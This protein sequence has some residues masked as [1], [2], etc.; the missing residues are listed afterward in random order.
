M[1]AK[2][3]NALTG[4]DGENVPVRPTYYDLYDDQDA[5]LMRAPLGVIAAVLDLHRDAKARAKAECA[6]PGGVCTLHANGRL[7]LGGR[8][9][10]LQEAVGPRAN[11]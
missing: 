10:T 9:C 4:P 3:P 1:T 2:T 7:R 11:Y 5:F 6:A 8:Y